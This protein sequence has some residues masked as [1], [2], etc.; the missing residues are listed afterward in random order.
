MEVNVNWCFLDDEA[1]LV[2]PDVATPVMAIPDLALLP[3][4]GDVVFINPR[5]AWVVLQRVFQQTSPQQLQV[6][7]WLGHCPDPPA[8]RRRPGLALV[9]P[10]PQTGPSAPG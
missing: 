4:M 8:L 5:S 7:L 3:N 9:P 6:Q 2:P 10:S 1:H